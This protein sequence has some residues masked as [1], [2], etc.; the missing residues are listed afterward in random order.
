[1]GHER[2]MSWVEEVYVPRDDDDGGGGGDQAC[3]T[4]AQGQHDSSPVWHVLAY[5]SL[6]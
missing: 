2:V 4:L 6:L 1:M 5:R 3:L